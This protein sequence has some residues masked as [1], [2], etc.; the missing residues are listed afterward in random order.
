MEKTKEVQD[1][2]SAS[3]KTTSISPEK[4]GDDEEIHG[5]KFEQ[6]KG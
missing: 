4:G 2:N 6:K 1:L 5:T 3:M